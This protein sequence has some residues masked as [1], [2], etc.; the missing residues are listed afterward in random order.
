MAS[1]NRFPQ[2]VRGVSALGEARLRELAQHAH[3][4]VGNKQSSTQLATR[5]LA[6]LELPAELNRFGIT[7]SDLEVIGRALGLGARAAW[8]PS[9][10][11]EEFERLP[12]Y[13]K[14][15][16]EQE[17][18]NALVAEDANAKAPPARRKPVRKTKPAA[19]RSTAAVKRKRR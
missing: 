3:V 15:S 8:R 17:V 6:K 10:S 11:A 7:D 12:F 13:K 9:I 19:K 18:W 4:A 16:Y 5:L 14:P 1:E 2:F